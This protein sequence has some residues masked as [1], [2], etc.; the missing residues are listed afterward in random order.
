MIISCQNC[1][2]RFTLPDGQMPVG[3]RKVRCS[4]CSNVWFATAEEDEAAPT[5]EENENATPIEEPIT[6]IEED[7]ATT[8][9]EA[10]IEAEAEADVIPSSEGTADK[11]AAIRAAM[12]EDAELIDGDTSADQDKVSITEEDEIPETDLGDDGSDEDVAIEGGVTDPEE[13]EERFADDADDIDDDDSDLFPADDFDDD[14]EFDEDDVIARRRRKQ[15]EEAEYKASSR[16]AQMA[17]V[18]WVFLFLFIAAIAGLFFMVPE[19]VV[20]WW[21]AANKIYDMAGVNSKPEPKRAA[22]TETPKV[23]ITPYA[24]TMIADGDGYK[25]TLSGKIVNE[26]LRSITIPAV[27]FKLTNAEEKEI[28]MG[29]FCL[30]SRILRK[31]QSVEFEHIINPASVETA[32]ADFEIKW[33]KDKNGKTIDTC[34]TKVSNAQNR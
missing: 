2:A 10:E 5:T 28:S 33:E 1:F 3:G 32:K 25:L 13:I 17:A 9:F 34:A 24:S 23:R 29:S 8:S 4:S 6:S 30:P 18:G 14:E 21:P 7:E 19:R 27:T 16:K 11:L 12:V 22:V 26:G 15:R 20:S 31:G